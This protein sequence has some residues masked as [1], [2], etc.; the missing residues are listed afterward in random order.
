P[1]EHLYLAGGLFLLLLLLA[2]I[3][4][5][6]NASQSAGRSLVSV[7]ITVTSGQPVAQSPQQVPESSEAPL[8]DIVM[9]PSS[10]LSGMPDPQWQRIE[11]QSGDNLTAIF[12]KV[13]LT[14]QD[15]FQ[16][17]NSSEDA[18]VLNRLYPGYELNFMIPDDGLLQQ[19]TVAK[20]PLEGVTFTRNESGYTAEP[21]LKQPQVQ[22][23]FK[24]G[25]ITDSLFMAGQREQIPAVHIM[26][27]ANIFGGVIDFILDPRSGDQF[28]ILY[29][30]KY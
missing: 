28:S 17:L 22:Q 7:P 2:I 24:V 29:E 21:Y 20:S 10:S 6:E 12:S 11:V 3:P 23:A 27:M 25:T 4:G 15:L 5:E 9:P 1:K 8:K 16:V 19:L 26:E 13:G 30:E 18:S 14:D